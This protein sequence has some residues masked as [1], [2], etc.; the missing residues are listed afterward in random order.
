MSLQNSIPHRQAIDAGDT[1][2]ITTS[3][4]VRDRERGF[5]AYLLRKYFRIP[6]DKVKKA[7]WALQ[8][9]S[10]YCPSKFWEQLAGF[11]ISAAI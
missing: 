10:M 4:A 11:T 8:Q 9:I 5:I 3:Q 6:L 7:K 1:E 2:A